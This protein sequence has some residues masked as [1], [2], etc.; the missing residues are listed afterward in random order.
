MG[1]FL[2]KQNRL[3]FKS[4]SFVVW[5][6]FTRWNVQ[7]ELKSDQ[8]R[9]FWWCQFFSIDPENVFDFLGMKAKC[10]IIFKVDKSLF[11]YFDQ[12]FERFSFNIIKF[13]A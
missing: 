3:S 6:N 9:E 10:K 12:S 1:L 11:S 4:Q 5:A 2:I 7:A 13:C 8:D